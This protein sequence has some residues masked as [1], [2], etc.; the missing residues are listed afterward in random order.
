MVIVNINPRYKAIANRYEYSCFMRRGLVASDTSTA[1]LFTDVIDSSYI[2]IICTISSLEF[3]AFA[4]MA[5]P[6]Y[7]A[8]SVFKQP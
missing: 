1:R 2:L 7:D 8:V 4:G 3:Q 5:W 6:D